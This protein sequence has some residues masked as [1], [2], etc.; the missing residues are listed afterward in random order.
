MATGFDP[1]E[2][3]EQLNLDLEKN[4]QWATKWKVIFNAKKSKDNIFSNIFLNNSPPVIFGD[5]FF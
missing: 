5:F 2:T 4:A 3:A 1:A